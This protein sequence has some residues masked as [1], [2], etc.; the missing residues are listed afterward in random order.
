MVGPGAPENSLAAIRGAA[1]NGFDMVEVDVL[2]SLDDQPILFHDDWSGTLRVSCGVDRAVHELTREELRDTCY[3][4]SDEHVAGLDEVLALCAELQ[5]GVMLDFKVEP[6]T[7]RLLARVGEL[8][9]ACGMTHAAVTISYDPGIRTGL[10]GRL[11]QRVQPEEAERAAVLDPGALAGQFWLDLPE[12]LPSGACSRCSGPAPWSCQHSTRSA[13]RPT[14]T[15]SWPLPTRRASRP[16]AST[17]SRSTRSIGICLRSSRD[18]H[19][20]KS[21]CEVLIWHSAT[22][23]LVCKADTIRTSHWQRPR[24]LARCH[25]AGGRFARCRSARAPV[26]RPGSAGR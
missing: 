9:E 3:L 6:A 26:R 2:A 15:A 14:R 21:A 19:W 18:V 5:I 23:V 11:L 22:S 20:R 8:L 12:D 7:D 25:R 24:T 4:A 16:P 1:A 10:S 13:T 17:A